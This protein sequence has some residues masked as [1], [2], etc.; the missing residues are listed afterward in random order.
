MTET[1]L[2]DVVVQGV[3]SKVVRRECCDGKERRKER[4]RKK[5]SGFITS[6]RASVN[7]DESR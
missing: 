4:G 6:P 3:M 2:Q 7:E 5:S 1:S